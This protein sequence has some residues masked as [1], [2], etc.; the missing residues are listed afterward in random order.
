MEY[1]V[2]DLLPDLPFWSVIFNTKQERSCN[3]NA[4]IHFKQVKA[5]G[6]LGLKAGVF[7]DKIF[8]A[9]KAAF[10]LLDLPP[11]IV[12]SRKR[13]G[14]IINEP[15]NMLS[16][17]S[18]K[19]CKKQRKSSRV[20]YQNTDLLKKNVNLEIKNTAPLT[21]NTNATIMNKDYY[22]CDN[23]NR[24]Y[25]VARIKNINDDEDNHIYLL[26]NDY[27]TLYTNLNDTRKMWLTNF[28]IDYCSN[29]FINDSLKCDE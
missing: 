14:P 15:D 12:C 2:D 24:D 29:L 6:E 1:L 28:L 13:P 20:S 21:K 5:E 26:G 7:I 25:F 19:D 18:W 22:F 9:I 10:K 16:E 8:L 4:E 11:P 17:E 27:R 23:I 3:S